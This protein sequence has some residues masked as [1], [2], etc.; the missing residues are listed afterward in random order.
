MVS[1]SQIQPSTSDELSAGGR[2]VATDGRVLPLE[3]TSIRVD[4]AGG[5]ARVILE[6]RFHNPYAEALRVKYLL[7]L[8]ADGAVGGFQFQVGDLTVRGEIDKKKRARERF[9]AALAEG[10]TA[11]LLEQS[12]SSVFQE[13]VGNIPPRQRVIVEVVIDQKL[14]WLDEGAWEWRFPTV[15]GPRYMGGPGPVI[16]G[17]NPP[18]GAIASLNAGGRV[19]DAAQMQVDVASGPIAHRVML[20]M[21]VRDN[22]PAGGRFESPSHALDIAPMAGRTMVALK[23]PAGARLDRDVVVRWPVATLD[24]GVGLFAARPAAEAHH[25]RAYGLLTLVPPEAQARMAPL[26]R[27]LIFLIDTSGSMSGD[28]L[29]QAKR[30]VAAMIDSLEED[31]RLEL[32]EFSSHPRRWKGEA[33]VAT[34]DGKA[35][36][37]RWVQRLSASGSTEMKA[38][39]LEALV[40]L[41]KSAQRQIVV[42]T[43]GYIGFEQEILETV[44][45][46]LPVGARVHTMGVG[47]AVNRSLTGPLARAGAGIEVIVAPGEDAE[48]AAKRLV[49]R[50][51]A[52]LV[53]ELKVEGP[54]VVGTVPAHLP[55]LF[56]R[57]P[58]MIAAELNPDGGEIRV[59]GTLAGGERY[60]HRAVAPKLALGAGNGAITGL[61]GRELV[62]DLEARKAAEPGSQEIDPEIE[63]LG[64]VFQIATRLT[65]WVAISEERLIPAG[66]KQREETM[67][68]ELPAGVS[69]QGIGLRAAQGKLAPIG[70]AQ[71]V[72][73]EEPL[74]F[75]AKK[76]DTGVLRG[77]SSFER[78]LRGLDQDLDGDA[79]E[80]LLDQDEATET[81]TARASSAP[82]RISAR[83]GAPAPKGGAAMKPPAP[84]QTPA[85]GAPKAPAAAPSRQASGAEPPADKA[86]ERLEAPAEESSYGT[87][88]QAA[89]PSGEPY[90]SVRP[91]V[92]GTGQGVEVTRM[93][94]RG[95]LALIAFVIVAIAIAIAL[96]F[97]YTQGATSM[98]TERPPRPGVERTV[99][100]EAPR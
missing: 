40:P 39:I 1:V 45:D 61:F 95:W 73:L 34:R 65:S 11:A 89:P 27:D 6:Q 53:T 36:A 29:N 43:D 49:A 38:A 2:L 50:T 100:S 28:P 33:V 63:R 12:R 18:A 7:P 51:V 17:M 94:G 67:P 98:K 69:A 72:D 20:T 24:V 78:R 41:R 62:E 80:D 66:L 48:R 76:A 42:I 10:R 64:L 52:P 84:A 75:M 54:G 83:L 30:V 70:L 88:P 37:L 55:D 21:H 86:K 96:W 44:L 19:P 47:S 13:E 32:I 59:V 81:E 85:Q 60:E 92:G 99:P 90:L 57:S 3:Q 15:V 14:S 35:E 87:A 71:S 26:P 5:I 82:P 97:A 58:V 31:D 79:G 56:Q 46:H 93:R 9:E 8:P 91:S 25:G 74:D 68:H 16:G 22:V 77:K 4:A 23:D